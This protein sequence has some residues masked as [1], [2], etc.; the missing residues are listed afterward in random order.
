MEKT[1][2]TMGKFNELSYQRPDVKE[3]KKNFAKHLKRFQTAA[4]FEDTDAAFLDFM[5]SMESWTTQDTIASIRNTMNVK[6]EFYDKEIKFYNSQ[7]SVLALTLKKAIK[8]TRL[9]IDYRK[10]CGHTVDSI[11]EACDKAEARL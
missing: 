2:L 5:G 6:D 3:L 7:N 11:E 9:H 4:T 8:A 10:S 1:N